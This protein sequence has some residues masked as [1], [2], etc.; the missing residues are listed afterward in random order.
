VVGQPRRLRRRQDLSQHFLQSGA[1][2]DSLIA[3]TSISQDDYVVEIGAGRGLLTSKLVESSQ[4]VVAIEIDGRLVDELRHRFRHE[5]RVEIVQAN[6]LRFDLLSHPYKVFGNIPYSRLLRSSDAW[7]MHL[8][9]LR[10][11]ISL[12][13]ARPLS[14][15]QPGH[16]PMKPRRRCF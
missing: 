1:L 3:N 13:S 6:F 10:T 4:R 9:L 16:M 7:S 2:A 15:S 5:S 8:F 12:S 11:P 14:V